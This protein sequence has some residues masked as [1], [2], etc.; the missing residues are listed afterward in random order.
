MA[1]RDEKKTDIFLSTASAISVIA[2]AIQPALEEKHFT[3]KE[4]Q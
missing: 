2:A 3:I 1:A 4:N